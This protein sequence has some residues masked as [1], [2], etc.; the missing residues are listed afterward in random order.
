MNRRLNVRGEAKPLGGA[1]A[2]ASPK[3]ANSRVY[4]NP[5]RGDLRMARVKRG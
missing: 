4:Y 5:K 2:K 3:W 1:A